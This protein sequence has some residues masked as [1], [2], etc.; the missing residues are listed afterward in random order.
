MQRCGAPAAATTTKEAA[1]IFRFE[2]VS[3]L[4]EPVR[5]LPVTNLPLGNVWGLAIGA[6]TIAIVTIA[7]AV[8]NAKRH[9]ET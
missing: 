2:P 4:P 5:T 6:I 7:A 3:N 1:K 8:A 9:H